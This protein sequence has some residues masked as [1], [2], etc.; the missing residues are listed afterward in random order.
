MEQL[1]QVTFAVTFIWSIPTY[2]WENAWDQTKSA[3]LKTC[4]DN[5]TR[6]TKRKQKRAANNQERKVLT[7]LIKCILHSFRGVGARIMSTC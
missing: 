4:D 6:R 1:W 7:P 2:K 3:S 5:N